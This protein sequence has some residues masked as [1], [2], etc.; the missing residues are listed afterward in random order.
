VVA[1]EG[2]RLCRQL[3]MQAL[4]IFMLAELGNTL[5]A[6]DNLEAARAAH[7]EAQAINQ[8][9]PSQPFAE[10]VSAELCA[11]LALAG[12]W[13]AAGEYARQ[14][15][16]GRGRVKVPFFGLTLWLETEAL[17][18]CGQIE[19]ARADVA[20]FG[21]QFNG[22]PRFRIPYWR[23]LAALALADGQP[24]VARAHLREAADTADELN[25]PVE[26]AQILASLAGLS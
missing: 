19:A 22:S 1:E 5:R 4:S 20:R 10:L 24:V 14:A 18:R 13:D 16:A 9:F 6:A 23:A 8:K 3:G 11:D 17:I 26:R 7:Q 2:A 15:L 12:D 21:Q 25:L